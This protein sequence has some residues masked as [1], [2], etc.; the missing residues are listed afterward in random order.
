MPS[1]L[2]VSRTATTSWARGVKA[3]P[4]F[5]IN[6]LSFGGL[7]VTNFK[8]LFTAKDTWLGPELNL[9]F[10]AIYNLYWDP[11]EAV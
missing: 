7:R 10:P 6:D 1:S 4:F 3:G 9:D 5:Y 11:G 2:M 8:A